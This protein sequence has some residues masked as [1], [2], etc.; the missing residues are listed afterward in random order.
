MD[1]QKLFELYDRNLNCH[2][3]LSLLW[4]FCVSSRLLNILVERAYRGKPNKK[5]L[6]SKM[7]EVSVL[8][9]QVAYFYGWE[10][11]QKQRLARIDKLEQIVEYETKFRDYYIDI[12]S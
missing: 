5:L 7:A 1:N 10:E 3:I 6:I 9:E 12:D 11:Y 8:I 2:G 4:Y